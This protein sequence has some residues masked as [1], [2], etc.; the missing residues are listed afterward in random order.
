[1]NHRLLGLLPM[2]LTAATL[3]AQLAGAYVV[4]PAGNYAN[5]AAAIA[6]LTTTGVSGPVTFLVTAN[7]A[8]PWTLPAFPGQGPLT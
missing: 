1:M 2:A 8:G 4:G 7:D 3:P 6:A 5:I